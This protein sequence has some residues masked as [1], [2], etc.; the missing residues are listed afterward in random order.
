[1]LQIITLLL[2]VMYNSSVCG[3]TAPYGSWCLPRPCLKG[4]L[5]YQWAQQIISSRL[6]YSQLTIRCSHILSGARLLQTS[7]LRT[8][9]LK[10]CVQLNG[11]GMWN[12]VWSLLYADMNK[13]KVGRTSSSRLEPGLQPHTHMV[14]GHEVQKVPVV[15]VEGHDVMDSFTGRQLEGPLIGQGHVRQESQLWSTDTRAEDRGWSCRI[16]NRCKTNTFWGKMCTRKSQLS[17][18]LLHTQKKNLPNNET[19]SM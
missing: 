15:G 5:S 18:C 10:V 4:A 9:A 7:W 14:R 12:E 1:M 13:S 8:A 16:G 19:C 6:H 2:S 11:G 17:R 3:N